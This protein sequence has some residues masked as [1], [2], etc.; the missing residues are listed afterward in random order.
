MLN[1]RNLKISIE[2]II[3]KDIHTYIKKLLPALKLVIHIPARRLEPTFVLMFALLPSKMILFLT[4]EVK[5]DFFNEFRRFVKWFGRNYSKF[6]L[7][8]IM[9]YNI[10][11]PESK[12]FEKFNLKYYS[13]FLWKI[14]NENIKS[15][16]RENKILFD[17]SGGTKL[18]SIILYNFALKNRFPFSYLYTREIRGEKG[19]FAIPGEEK[20]FIKL[21]ESQAINLLS[22]DKFVDVNLKLKNQSFTLD[23]RLNNKV[24]EKTI[25]VDL[26]ELRVLKENL[27]RIYK[28]ASEYIIFKRN[29]NILNE[30]KDISR[31]FLKKFFPERFLEI[32]D[33]YR[34][35]RFYFDK[36]SYFLPV[37]FFLYYEKNTFC[38][39]D[40]I[41]DF[42][43]FP[44]LSENE[45][46]KDYS[47]CMLILVNYR[48][49]YEKELFLR[50]ADDISKIANQN[51]IRAIIKTNL[52]SQKALYY[53]NKN[54]NIIH[55]IGHT[56]FDI[57]GSFLEFKNSKLYPKDIGSKI[58][59]MF[60]SNSC[61]SSPLIKVRVNKS[62]PYNFL[63]YGGKTF[64]GTFWEIDSEDAYNF[65]I[66]F[67]KKFLSGN[68]VGNAFFS[69]VQEYSKYN[70]IPANYHIY[71]DAL[72]TL[73]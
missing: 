41:F 53:L 49:K 11:S 26:K 1:Y 57:R 19:I 48:N 46:Q 60:F 50:E 6:R 4:P 71:G 20:F 28:K 56:G 23:F 67:Y 59:D 44:A 12:I 72:Y 29:Q 69:T 27:E 24:Y 35:F 73:D 34:Y 7:P 21:P 16:H 42:S 22:I 43:Y 38:I 45:L 61:N 17:L 64:I 58:A 3:S 65:A 2:N 47:K 15:R 52:D 70:F 9:I 30:I 51:S 63:K 32:T 10:E 18:H 33:T 36:N 40:F 14:I 25:P 39:R 66:S 5:L 62:F 8:E 13:N 31:K 68:S 37:D 54:W 55:F